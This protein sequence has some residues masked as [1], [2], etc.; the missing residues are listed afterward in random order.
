MRSINKLIEVK[1][2]SWFAR[3]IVYPDNQRYIPEYAVKISEMEKV[4]LPACRKK[5][6][7]QIKDSIVT[8][9]I[10][11][12]LSA[13]YFQQVKPLYENIKENIVVNIT[14]TNA[15][16]FN[17]PINLMMTA[18]CTDAADVTIFSDVTGDYLMRLFRHISTITVAPYE[19][20]S[21]Q[22]LYSLKYDNV[23]LNDM[24]PRSMQFKNMV[25][26]T[27]TDKF[28]ELINN[29]NLLLAFADIYDG[30]LDDDTL[31]I[32]D[33]PDGV[34]LI[35]YD[36]FT[37]AFEG[38]EIYLEGPDVSRRYNS[39]YGANN[40]DASFVELLQRM[41]IHKLKKEAVDE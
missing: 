1:H 2:G 34:E 27:R 41:I 17:T 18:L 25:P 12:D 28:K 19:D 35:N 20:A 29:G 10:V 4:K 31:E 22:Y 5:I 15:S 23:T 33:L 6:F 9:N 38:N 36:Q 26:V 37:G 14:E 24:S 11:E 39:V 21:G 30:N 40:F 7:E 8:D 32:T 3:Y 13:A 16:A